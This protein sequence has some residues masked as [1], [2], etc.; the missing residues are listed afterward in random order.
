M[1]SVAHI[2]NGK[3]IETADTTA[4]KKTADANS[5]L[6]KD[7]FLQLLVAQMKYQDPMEPTSNTEYVAQYAQFS[8]VESLQNM[9]A[10]MD[11][12]SAMQLV[13][14]YVT[15]DVTKASGEVTSVSGR[16]DYVERSGAKTLLYI[17]GVPYNY[18]NLNTVW[19]DEYLDAYDLCST[20]SKSVASLPSAEKITLDYKDAVSTLRAAYDSMSAY[21]RG[22]IDMTVVNKLVAVENRIKALENAAAN[23]SGDDNKSEADSG[24]DKA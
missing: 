7:A 5:S 8:Q 11:S 1:G 4:A 20:W 6:D 16:V 9:S 13:G 15:M 2:N 3:V 18:E 19:D 17:D 22:F 23:P 14:K 24:A 12:T 10:A 21:Q